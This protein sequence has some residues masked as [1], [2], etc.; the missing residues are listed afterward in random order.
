MVT[1]LVRHYDQEER[2]S[3]AA[4]DKAEIG[5]SVLEQSST[6]FLRHRL[7][8]IHPVEEVA[9]RGSSIARI[10]KIP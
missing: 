7:A 8:S 9:R 2:Q 4:D 6:R 1:R 5:E 3:D 10:P